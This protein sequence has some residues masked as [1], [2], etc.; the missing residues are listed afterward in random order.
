VF[1]YEH[2]GLEQ[3]HSINYSGGDLRDEPSLPTGSINSLNAG[4]KA[5]V[6]VW[7]SSINPPEVYAFG[8]G[9]PSA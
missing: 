2:A 8:N 7:E 4:G 9:A 5:L 6:G 3:L 1:S